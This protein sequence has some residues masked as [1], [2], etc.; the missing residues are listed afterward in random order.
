MTGDRPTFTV[1]A[2]AS[3][4]DRRLISP[5]TVR[6][7]TGL[8]ET[9]AGDETLTLLLDGVLATCARYCKL[10]RVGAQPPTFA[11]EVVR[12]TWPDVSVL[13]YPLP[14][15]R[16]NQLL[17]PWRTPITAITVVEGETELEQDVDYRLLGAGVVER[18]G[19]GSLCCWSSSGVVV[20]YTAGWIATP[21]DPSYEESEGEP[22]PPDLVALI[23]G[24]VNLQFLQRG[25]D[26]TLRSED[27]PGVWSGSYNVPGG[28]AISGYGLGFPLQMALDAYRAPPSV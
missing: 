14:W 28:D 27:V 20:D 23:A 4:T 2:A 9:D 11:E 25:Q 22:M 18:L 19:T 16:S 17:L 26:P 24:Q 21:T 12:A 10:A 7:L 1:V 13:D 3:S 5:A 15:R 6:A 8:T